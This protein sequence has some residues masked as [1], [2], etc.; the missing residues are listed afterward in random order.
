VVTGSGDGTARIWNVATG[1]EIRVINGHDG[2]VRSAVFS[3]DGKRVVTASVDRS[4]RTWDAENGWELHRL[5]GHEGTVHSAAFSADGKFLITASEDKTAR[6]WPVFSTTQALTDVAKI[7]VPRCLTPEQREKAFL[8]PEPPV[9]CVE[10][11]K[12]P[13]DGRDWKDWLNSRRAGGNPPL[14]QH[15]T[16]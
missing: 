15:K 13:Y 4:V 10:M 3:P 9:W 11:E 6:I 1:Q 16:E 5:V 2:V 14:P 8:D 7:V 12:W